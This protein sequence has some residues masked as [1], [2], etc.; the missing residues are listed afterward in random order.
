MCDG[1]HVYVF[2]ESLHEALQ[3][4]G[5]SPNND[6]AR[7]LTFGCQQLAY[8]LQRLQDGGRVTT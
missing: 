2:C 5:G 3:D 6:N 4:E 8:C 7:G 1:D